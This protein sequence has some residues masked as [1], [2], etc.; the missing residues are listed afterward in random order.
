MLLEPANP[1]PVI[2]TVS[3]TFPLVG[4]SVILGV[5]VKLALA[6]LLAPSDATTACAPAV[7]AGTANVAENPP[8]PSVVGDAG[9]SVSALPPYVA[10]TLLEP[11]NPLPVI[12]TVSPT[13]PL[14]GLSV[15]LGVTVKEVVA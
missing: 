2:V 3:P 5:T 4:L 8:E 9:L 14:D 13:C 11:A 6:L 7:L 10:P 15:I 1:V 12:V